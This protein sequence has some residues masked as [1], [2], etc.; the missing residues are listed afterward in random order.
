ENG[1]SQSIR[2]G[3]ANVVITKAAAIGKTE[4]LSLILEKYATI[5]SAQDLE[6]ACR[7]AAN[8]A[9]TKTL[10]V[11]LSAFFQTQSVENGN[12]QCM[13]KLTGLTLEDAVSQLIQDSTVGLTGKSFRSALQWFAYKGNIQGLSELLTRGVN[14]NSLSGEHGTALQAASRKGHL[15]T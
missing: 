14:I 11:L 5:C 13:K 15:P 8:R 3:V 7:I 9:D 12:W 6:N 4:A 10:K 2:Q 1:P